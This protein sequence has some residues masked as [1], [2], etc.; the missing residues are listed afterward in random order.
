MIRH[1]VALRF[2][3]TL[4]EAEKDRLYAALQALNLPGLLEFRTFRN[5]S[6]EAPVTHGFQDLFWFDFRDAEARDLYLTDPGHQAIGAQLVA[7]TGGPDGIQVLD[8]EL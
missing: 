6:P 2:P 7:A 3:A 5:I 8:V 4:A 1:I